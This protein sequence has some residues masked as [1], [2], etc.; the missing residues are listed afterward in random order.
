MVEQMEKNRVRLDLFSNPEFDRGRSKL[1]ELLWLLFAGWLVASHLPGSAWRRGLLRLF[2]AQIGKGVVIKPR[3]SIKFPWRLTV[4]NYCWIGEGVWID[5]LGQVTLGAHV[6]LS[7]AAY[8][9][10]GSHD[11]SAERFDLIVLPITLETGSW[12]AASARIAPGSVLA[13]GAVVSMGSVFKGHSNP[14]TIYKGNLAVAAKTRRTVQPM[15]K[16]LD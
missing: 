8:L 15:G 12:V 1:T 2:G 3:V 13:E 7:Q 14:W 9:C 10:T 6:C 4:G 16:V 11:W 5:N